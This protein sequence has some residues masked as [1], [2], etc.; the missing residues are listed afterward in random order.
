MYRRE[1]RRIFFPNLVDETTEKPAS[2]KVCA[3]LP[4]GTQQ[5]TYNGS[6]A[7]ALQRGL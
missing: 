1:S 6:G 5:A 7:V 2:P 3:K 4:R